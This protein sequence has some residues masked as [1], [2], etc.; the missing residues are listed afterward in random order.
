[1]K[2]VVL[3]KTFNGPMNSDDWIFHLEY[4]ADTNE[5]ATRFKGLQVHLASKAAI[6][7]YFPESK[8]YLQAL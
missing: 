5:D 8:Q 7:H 2:P 3:S 4:V 1:M 6:F